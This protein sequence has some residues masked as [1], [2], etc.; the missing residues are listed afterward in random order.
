MSTPRAGRAVSVT[1]KV[2]LQFDG[3]ADLPT[4]DD[5]DGDEC[6]ESENFS[7][8]GIEWLLRIYPWDTRTD[9]MMVS[10]SLRNLSDRNIH[11]DYSFSVKGHAG[12]EVY[13]SLF[14]GEEDCDNSW[15][16][17]IGM[18][19]KIVQTLVDGALV[20]EVCM[21]LAD[22]T[23]KTHT[24]FIPEN[25]SCKI[26]Q[27]MFMDERSSDVLFELGGQQFNSKERK[28]TK[29]SPVTFPAHH[30][31]LTKCSSTLA[32]LCG[33]AKD[34]TAPIRIH[35]VSPDVFRH[36]LHHLYGRKISDDDMKTHAKEIVDAA[37]RWGVVDLKLM[38]EACLVQTT[39][40]GVE[41]L[42]DLLLYADSKNC[43]LLK[44]AAMDFIL[45][46]RDEVLK[47]LSFDDAPGSLVRDVLAA[48]KRGEKRSKAREGGTDL[49]AIS[50]S[51]LRWKAHRNGLNVDG[52]REML[53]AALEREHE[54]VVDG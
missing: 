42:L 38:A 35:D 5:G 18:R 53:I 8:L 37:D 22:K 52:S 13:T 48:M 14:K 50:I 33:S 26:I 21:K 27:G 19:S 1:T 12:G 15:G 11:I 23:Q 28:K 16:D 45:E 7:C 47:K 46:N 24:P 34:K 3:F 49:S 2:Q 40:F 9:E 54:D 32:K 17:D 31:I 41:N 51:E 25:P 20:I 36:L 44:E 10:A 4:Q 43:A 6:A 30:L 29:T 39:A